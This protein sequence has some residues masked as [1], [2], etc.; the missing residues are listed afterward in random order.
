MFNS[1]KD[2]EESKDSINFEYYPEEALEFAREHL[3]FVKKIEKWLTD[4]VLQ[5]STRSFS[6]LAPNRKGFLTMLVFE[7]F[8][9]DMCIYGG[10]N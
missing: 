8:H 4:V 3:K 1:A 7:H 2:F 5:K 9:L 10:R 6:G